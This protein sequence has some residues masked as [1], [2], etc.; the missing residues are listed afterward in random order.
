MLSNERV[1]H[2]SLAV[3]LEDL[4][5]VVDVVVLVG[6]HQVCHRQNLGVILVW[7]RLLQNKILRTQVPKR[8]QLS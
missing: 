4:L 7:L 6:R 3:L 1:F 5:K 2:D 8:G